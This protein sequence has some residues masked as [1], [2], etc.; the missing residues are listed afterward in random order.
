MFVFF[1]IFFIF[2]ILFSVDR[3]VSAR[4]SILLFVKNNKTEKHLDMIMQIVRCLNF[5]YIYARTYEYDYEY[6][7]IF[8]Y[9]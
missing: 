1:F 6:N 3:V 5:I 2:W 8:V 7:Y 9:V 4:N